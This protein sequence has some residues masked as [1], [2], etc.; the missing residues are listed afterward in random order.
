MIIVCINC[1]FLKWKW[2]SESDVT[3]GQVWWPILGIRTLHL[4]LPKCTHTAVN[5]HTSVNIHPE[6]WAAIYAAAPGEQSRVWCLAQRPLSR[7]IE[8][9]R[10]R[11]TF[12]PPTYNSCRTWD[13]NSQYLLVNNYIYLFR[14]LIENKNIAPQQILESSRFDCIN[15]TFYINLSKKK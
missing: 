8:G 11:C 1:I 4:T 3:C 5:T 13:S 9:G 12:T 15:L 14:I 10:E 6:Q 2:K 7:G